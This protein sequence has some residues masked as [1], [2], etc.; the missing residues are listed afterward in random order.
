LTIPEFV[1]TK[2]LK[3]KPLKAATNAVL[4]SLI[5][6]E[7]RVGTARI[8][9]NPHDPVTSGALFLKVYERPETDFFLA[10]FKP[11][12]SFL[13]IGANVGYYTA[14]ALSRTEGQ[15]RVVAIEPDPENFSYL[16]KTV[17]ANGGTNTTC[18]H[19]AAAD[20]AGIMT[21]Y[22]CA[23]NR[24]DNRLYD[25]ELRS[26]TCTVDVVTVDELLKSLSLESVDYIKMDVQGYEAHVLRG[27]Q[28]TLGGSHPLV[29]VMEFW[30]HGLTGAGSKP[31]E[32]LEFLTAI[33]L[34][35]FELT[36]KA[37]LRRIQDYRELTARLPGT[38]YTN[39]VAIRNTTLPPSM[40]TQ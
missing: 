40:F 6:A 13:D 7:L 21:L 3:P 38:Q 17:L 15:S 23:D 9:L 35:L 24:G 25:N 36:P 27:M 2:L 28:R 10:T 11:G 14:L 39:I 22:V 33:G 8:A 18:V 29:L 31:V 30:P 26:G 32:V 37:R 19:K 12:M 16:Q 5:P 1:Y 34:Q 4:R 20:K